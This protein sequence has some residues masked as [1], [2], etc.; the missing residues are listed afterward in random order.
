[1]CP[2]TVPVNPA[3]ELPHLFAVVTGR[4]FQQIH[5]WSYENVLGAEARVEGRIQPPAGYATRW[6]MLLSHCASTSSPDMSGIQHD[7]ID[8]LAGLFLPSDTNEGCS[9]DIPQRAIHLREAGPYLPNETDSL[10]HFSSKEIPS[11]KNAVLIPGKGC[12]STAE[13]N[14]YPQENLGSQKDSAVTQSFEDEQPIVRDSLQRPISSSESPPSLPGTDLHEVSLAEGFHE[15]TGTNTVNLNLPSGS[16]IDMRHAFKPCEAQSNAND[17][18]NDTMQLDVPVDETLGDSESIEPMQNSAVDVMTPAEL[19]TGIESRLSEEQNLEENGPVALGTPCEETSDMNDAVNPSDQP[20]EGHQFIGSRSIACQS[21][22]SCRETNSVRIPRLDQDRCPEPP[23]HVNLE[24]TV[25]HNE[26]VTPCE[27]AEIAASPC[28]SINKGLDSD[29]N[30][31]I[32]SPPKHAQLI[33][34][35][36]SAPPTLHSPSPIQPRTKQV[37]FSHA[38]IRSLQEPDPNSG[39]E[40]PVTQCAGSDFEN[41]N[42]NSPSNAHCPWR[43]SG[44]TLSIDIHEAEHIPI[45]IGYSTFWVVDGQ[46][47]QTMTLSQGNVE[48]APA[49]RPVHNLVEQDCSAE[50]RKKT[51]RP[52]SNRGSLS[53]DEK[54]KLVKLRDEGYTWN[55]IA[56]QF[57]HK[58]KGTLQ[59][60]YY[61]RLKNSRDQASPVHGHSKRRRPAYNSL[62]DR[63]NGA[64]QSTSDSSVYR[65]RLEPMS[66]PRYSFRARRCPRS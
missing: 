63:V 65:T 59:S 48:L 39:P 4:H 66:H 20:P 17:T 13:P 45:F 8:P 26:E 40:E 56:I 28:Y 55:E 50:N 12:P 36:M 24:A 21:P 47:F 7:E 41:T 58:K 30:Q 14:F 16:G 42:T 32:A 35:Q 22:S 1:M 46:L 5:T 43:L 10:G 19:D 6:R 23:A 34:G 9:L 52:P 44:T 27:D 51:G 11:A 2:S 33:N 31:P 3:R 60:I 18:A 49:K 25:L 53:P 57:P 54:R 37:E 61:S 38:E 62:N 29:T 15:S 64:S